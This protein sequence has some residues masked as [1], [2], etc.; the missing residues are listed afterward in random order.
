MLKVSVILPLYNAEDFIVEAVESVLNQTYSDIELIVVD[1]GSTDSS[2]KLLEP[3]SKRIKLISQENQ[4]GAAA[5]NRALE[6]A[7]G[8][9]IALIDHDDLWLPEKL[10]KQM[11][12][13][14][15]DPELGFVCCGTYVIDAEGNV[16]DCWVKPEHVENSFERLYERNFLHNLTFVFRK[17]C[18]LD[19]GGWASTLTSSDYDLS[20][21]LAKKFKFSYVR[22]PLAKYRIHQNNMSHNLGDR[23][24]AHLTI[25]NKP[26]I[27]GD[28]SA[29]RKRIRRGKTFYQFAEWFESKGQYLEAAKCYS[30]SLLAIPFIGAY[31]WPEETKHFRF[32]FPYRILKVY[33]LVFWCALKGLGK[34]RGDNRA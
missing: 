21:R 17:G 24:K 34:S 27:S 1:D 4:G 30:N 5:R 32:S 22:E 23:L 14:A 29:W 7:E 10:E 33:F 16:I 9:F 18:L 6:K 26:E 15:D 13:F 8:D 12:I 3:F 2:V 28:I 25:L 19:V 20:L 11:K 31:Y